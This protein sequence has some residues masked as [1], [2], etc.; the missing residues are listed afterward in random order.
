MFALWQ[1]PKSEHKRKGLIS[2]NSIIYHTNNN[3]DNSAPVKSGNLIDS[4]T[5]LGI[6]HHFLRE[7]QPRG[8][9]SKKQSIKREQMNSEN[10]KL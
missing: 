3:S 9:Q 10:K 1:S 8:V 4:L 5:L 2:G 6:S 7:Y